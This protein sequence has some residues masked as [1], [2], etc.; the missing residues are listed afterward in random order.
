MKKTLPL[1]L[2]S[3]MLL[4]ACASMQAQAV[5]LLNETWSSGQRD[6]Q[7]LPNS[8]RWYSSSPGDVTVARGSLT[9]RTPSTAFV[10]AYFTNGAPVTLE[11]GQTLEVKYSYSI[12]GIASSGG[13]F[14]AGVFNSTAGGRI[15]ADTFGTNKREF[16]GYRGYLVNKANISRGSVSLQKRVSTTSSNLMSAIAAYSGVGDSYSNW[17][18]LLSGITYNASLS[19][20]RN[21]DDSVTLVST[22]SDPN[23]EIYNV[24][25]TDSSDTCISFD[26]FAMAL[27]G[28]SGDAFVLRSVEARTI[29]G[30]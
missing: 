4:F 22:L 8:A 18:G 13:L 30:S 20:T 21:R 10:I 15:K 9:Q 12:T 3:S 6:V 26:T 27:G 28:D 11:P 25:R 7:N 19:I 14:R 2:I 29:P 1:S 16:T 5:N 17:P 24:S 23:G